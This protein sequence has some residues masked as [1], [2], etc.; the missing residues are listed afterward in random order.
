MTFN[1]LKIIK[2][3]FGS[4]LPLRRSRR[5]SPAHPNK[6]DNTRRPLARNTSDAAKAV[7]VQSCESYYT[8]GQ[9]VTPSTSHPRI[10][11]QGRFPRTKPGVQWSTSYMRPAELTELFNLIH[12]TLEHVPYAICGL[13]ALIDHGLTN[14]RA[15]RVSIICP[16]SSR[17]NV[18]AWAA[19]KGYE[20][21]AD[22]IGIPTHKGL[23]RR[24]RVK[25]IERG[26]ERLER[27]RSSCSNAIVL[28]IASQLDNVAA[29]WLDNK[30]RSDERALT[31]IAS[32]I[33]FCLDRIAARRQ[34]VDPRYLPTFLGEDFFT[35]F[36]AQYLNARPEMARA[37]IDVSAVL[38]KHRAAVSLRDH[39]E[40]LRQYGLYEEA[41]PQEPRGQFEDIGMSVYTIRDSP[42]QAGVKQLPTVPQPP[43]QVYQRTTSRDYS[44]PGPS[45][46]DGSTLSSRGRNLTAQRQMKPTPVE[47]PGA[48]WI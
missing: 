20:V 15:N 32:D 37:G 35:H 25:F 18:T 21:H 16:P 17:K 7:R 19:T 9:P 11:S 47:R 40:L 33:F 2:T 30:K 1:P 5:S 13:G 12:T 29:G 6:H 45:R 48:N 36:T 3:C 4:C 46:T 24:V 8:I 28:S 44:L 41:A 38:A 34:R 43:K 10:K 42:P 26:F 14:R 31:V 22:S 27:V 23:T 39:N